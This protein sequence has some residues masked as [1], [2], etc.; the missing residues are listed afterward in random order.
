[1]WLSHQGLGSLSNTVCGVSVY[2]SFQLFFLLWM[3]F[4]GCIFLCAA[5][6]VGHSFICVNTVKNPILVCLLQITFTHA[7]LWP[8][9]SGPHWG[10]ALSIAGSLPVWGGLGTVR[11]S[12]GVYVG[13]AGSLD[14]LDLPRLPSSSTAPAA[15][16][17]L[18]YRP[19][20]TTQHK[21]AESTCTAPQSLTQTGLREFAN[22]T[23][24]KPPLLCSE[25][26]ALHSLFF[27]RCY[28]NR[29]HSK[30]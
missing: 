23:I 13:L 17:P 5:K 15:Y 12:Q 11:V 10:T 1:M 6:A 19:A 22:D 20:G 4:L 8:R 9:P 24:I 27:F 30:S 21:P 25:A 2:C 14:A 16:P 26:A 7:H 18:S 29:N 28:M 3:K